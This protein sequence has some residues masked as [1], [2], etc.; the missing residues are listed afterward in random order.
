MMQ[1]NQVRVDVATGDAL[2]VRSF[3][4]TQQ[5]D[6]LFRVR[7]TAVSHNLSI[8]LA[9]VIGKDGSFSLGTANGSLQLHGVVI[10]LKQ[11]RVDEQGLAT[12]SLQLAPRAWLMSQRK[13]FRI[14]QFV[15]ELAI[16]LQL[17]AEWGVEVE[18]RIGRTHKPR[19]FRVQYDESD[20]DFACRM[21]EDAGIAFY[22]EAAEGGTRLVLDDQP[23]TRGLDFPLLAFE[24]QPQVT[25]ADFVTALT[26]KQRVK[27]GRMT[28]G[29]LDYR[30]A[31]DAQPRLS[32]TSGLAT[33]ARLEQFDYEPGAFLFQGEGGGTPAADDR[34][35][36][37]TDEGEGAARTQGRLLARRRGERE[38]RLESN[39]VA[40]RPGTRLSVANHPHRTVGMDQG[41]LLTAAEVAGE[42][43]ADWRVKVVAVPTSLPYRPL[44][45]TP[46]P[47]VPGLE[48]ATVVG[49]AGEEIHTDEYGRLRVHF[50]WDRES[51][52]NEASSCWLPTSQPWA[53]TGFGGVNLPRVGQEVLVEFLGGDP[54]RPVV[55]G[56][57][58][59]ETN[60]VPDKLPQFKEISGIMS[61]STPRMVMGGADGSTASPSS[62]LLGGGQPM[63]PGEIGSELGGKGPYA[64]N[65]PTSQMHD[66]QGS[67]IKLNDQNGNQ[68]IYLQAQR[69]LNI[70]VNNC[71]RTIVRKD[72]TCKVGT[73]DVL[74]VMNQH[75]TQVRGKQSVTIDG[76]QTVSVSGRRAERIDSRLELEVG[77]AFDITS[78]EDAINYYAKSTLSIESKTRMEFVV[79]G[80]RIEITPGQVTV[81]AAD[82]VYLQPGRGGFPKR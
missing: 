60:P 59:T 81:K 63:S 16:V 62:S 53:G 41:L 25:G 42:H 8:D 47:R 65:S 40:L 21:L 34:G 43:S 72:R 51:Q 74:E 29:D 79:K 80:S 82:R 44:H 30:R 23:E 24:D 66:W 1:S 11:L 15:S 52:R 6:A 45:D 46:K 61:E 76:N 73:D 56:R 7:L 67:G 50:H 31:S 49:P 38:V 32:S 35:A 77:Q 13:N 70:T 4:V 37:R 69:D 22:F 17:F 27:P 78:S 36:S 2:D 3:H 19:K 39:V 68:M 54:D 55:I 58:Y 14:F 26:V 5:M 20:F 10:E 71:W 33:E 64:A 48:S 9:E 75:E 28:V 18:S 57:V 12:Y